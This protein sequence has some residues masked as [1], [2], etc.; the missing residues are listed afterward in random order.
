MLRPN[1][2][3]SFITLN[4]T[5]KDWNTWICWKHPRG[6][7]GSN[8]SSP[9]WQ[10]YCTCLNCYISHGIS[11]KNAF[12]KPRASISPGPT[13]PPPPLPLS[14]VEASP[15]LRAVLR[16]GS[17]CKRWCDGDVVIEKV[18]VKYYNE[19][20]WPLNPI[21]NLWRKVKNKVRIG[22]IGINY[23][24]LSVAMV[25]K[26]FNRQ[27]FFAGW[28]IPSARQQKRCITVIRHRQCLHLPGRGGWNPKPFSQPRWPISGWMSALTSRN[29]CKMYNTA[30]PTNPL[31]WGE[32]RW[33][34]WQV[35][36]IIQ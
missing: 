14:G 24:L 13:E 27:M 22:E 33:T 31:H 16:S 9:Q 28:K 12:L 2:F 6:A 20:K 15:R 19:G 35:W 11:W 10:W 8:T 34:L 18:V 32:H 7:T 21:E 23:A 3:L 25:L 4:P 17:R 26:L 36:G 5:P 1:C 30:V 29:G